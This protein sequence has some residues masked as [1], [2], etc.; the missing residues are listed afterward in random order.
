LD[1]IL[2][3]NFEK[4]KESHRGWVAGHF[5]DE[6]SPL[7]ISDFEL[8]WGRH[9]KGEKR[10]DI[11]SASDVKSLAILISGKFKFDFPDENNSF[12]LEKEGDFCYYAG[13]SHSWEVLKDCLILTLRWPSVSSKD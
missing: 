7:K 12:V 5:L 3:G 13:V 8:K 11:A 6:D 1:K 4:E 2:F 9:K 10:E